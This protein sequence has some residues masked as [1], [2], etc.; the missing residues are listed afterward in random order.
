[1]EDEE[2]LRESPQYQD[3]GALFLRYNNIYNQHFVTDEN[4]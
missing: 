2:A 4:T 1:M 3:C